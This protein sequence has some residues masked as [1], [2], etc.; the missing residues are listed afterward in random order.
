MF[1]I[2][3]AGRKI[4]I[5]AA[6]LWDIEL[7]RRWPSDKVLERIAKVLE[8]DL[9]DLR[10]YDAR[11]PIKDIKRLCE[12]DD[13]YGVAFQKIMEHDVSAQELIKLAIMFPKRPWPLKTFPKDIS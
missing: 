3:K 7:G 10:K 1:T 8:A 4:G 6:F 13:F 11:P 12:K 5:S 2:R 9:D